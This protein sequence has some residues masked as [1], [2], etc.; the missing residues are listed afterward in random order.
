M[1]IEKDLKKDGI[2]VIKQLDTLSVT[3]ISKYVAEKLISA[4]P[5]YGL[6]YSNLFIK[7][8]NIPMFIADIPSSMGEASYFY[9]NS[10]I[11]FKDGLSIH[12]MKRYAVHEFIH[13]YQEIKDKSNIL[14]RLGLCDFTGIKVHGLALNEGAV[15][16]ISAKALGNDIENVKY[17]DIEFNTNTPSYYPIICNLVSQLAY[18]TGENVLF[19]S[20]LNSNSKFVKSLISLL[21]EKNFYKIESNLDKILKIEE[22]MISLSNKLENEFL[23]GAFIAKSSTKIGIYKNSIKNIFFETQ[24]L[25]IKSYFDRALN[26]V[27]SIQEIE[28]YRKK[29]YCYKDLLGVT[30]DYNFFNDYYINMMMKLDEKYEQA[31]NPELSLVPYTR[32]IF[33]IIIQKI[34][35]LIGV[36]RRR[37]EFCKSEIEYQ[38]GFASRTSDEKPLQFKISFFYK[39]WGS[40]GKVLNIS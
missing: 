33:E 32:S 24:N 16:L 28:D 3:L 2:T 15:Q 35:A 8:C 4:L 38:R 13:A 39:S 10:S 1:N 19:D 36:K 31:S 25:I 22:E 26:N 11:Y 34:R 9:K 14:Y 40:F 37:N 17:Y 27:Y 6:N 18:I 20:T 23:S 29:L 5:F 30:E 7:I 12:E 21:G